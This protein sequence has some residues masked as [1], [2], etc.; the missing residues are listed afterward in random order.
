[1]RQS[2]VALAILVWFLAAMSILVAGIVY[3]A[4]MDIKLAQL[5]IGQA[6]AQAAG[7][8]AINL[9]LAELMTQEEASEFGQRGIH[10]SKFSFNNVQV[11]VR[12]VPVTGLVNLNLATEA[13][14]AVLFTVGEEM[15]E[16][17]GQQLAASVVE[18]R[19]SMADDVAEDSGENQTPISSSIQGRFDA[20]ENLLL[21]DGVSRDVFD[22]VK[23]LVCVD[24]QGQA[25]VDW[26]S[27]PVAVLTMFASGNEDVAQGVARSRVLDPSGV[28]PSAVG[29][30]MLF[31]EEQ[32]LPRF[33]VDATVQIEETSYRRRRW[34]D[35]SKMGAD[36][37]PWRYFRTEPI[38]VLS[39]KE[40][41]MMAFVEDVYAGN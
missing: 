30:N 5:H 31:Q 2:G 16:G 33:R 22:H 34:V 28:A 4:R 7:D 17:R 13:L 25:G 41:E 18:W 32:S 3:Q 24:R 12:I 23:D 21:V 11:S 1:M 20:I 6:E 26:L 40:K 14:L 9:A 38:T 27:A 37:L 29:L 10:N 15:D 35:R 8:G 19:S 36:S 39:G